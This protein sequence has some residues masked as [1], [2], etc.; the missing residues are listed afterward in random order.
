MIFSW[1]DNPFFSSYYTN[2]VTLT[3]HGA[4]LLYAYDASTFYH[5]LRGVHGVPELGPT[6]AIIL[7]P[8]KAVHTYGSKQTLDVAF[9]DKRGVIQKL[10]TMPPKRFV[11][12]LKAMFVVE[13]A[14]GTAAR[15]QL[16]EGQTFLPSTGDWL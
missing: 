14:E 16:A 3:R 13:M 4:P 5:R 11:F 7:R 9:I 2:K 6:D 12:S 8:C 1:R 10:V 15:I